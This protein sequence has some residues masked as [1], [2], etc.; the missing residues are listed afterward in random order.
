LNEEQEDAIYSPIYDANW[1]EIDPVHRKFLERFLKLCPPKGSILDAP[2]GTGKYWPM[3]LASGMTVF[4]LDQSR[5]MLDQAVKKHPEIPVAKLGLQ[6][7]RS[8]QAFDGVICIDALEMVPPE[9]W[10]LVLGNLYRALIPGGYFYFTVETTS[11]EEKES[12][13]AD[14]QQAGLPVVFGEWAYEGGYHG[15][16][17][18]AGGY[19]YYPELGQVR[20]WVSE[21]GFNLLEEETDGLYQHF[22]AQR[23]G[24]NPLPGLG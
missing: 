8:Q 16:W 24:P 19:H 20:E 9:D 23:P 11:E 3:I 21:T 13:F 18:Q 6:E 12:A 7:L 2:C 17:A 15:D 22:L 4:G 5:G 14:A 1:G 10:P